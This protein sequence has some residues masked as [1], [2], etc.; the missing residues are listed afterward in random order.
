MERD[1]PK[2]ILSIRFHHVEVFGD[3]VRQYFF[4]FNAKPWELKTQEE[5]KRAREF[6]DEFV[7]SDMDSLRKSVYLFKKMVDIPEAKENLKYA[8]DLIGFTKQQSL[9]VVKGRLELFRSFFDLA[10]YENEFP[11]PLTSDLDTFCKTCAIGAHCHE[12]SVDPKENR[13]YVFQMALNAV[14]PNREPLHVT[15]KELFDRS[16]YQN[17]YEEVRKQGNGDWL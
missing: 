6:V 11:I 12:I 13:D 7:E 10:I 2:D 4:N 15:P 14:L 8:R 3:F 9:G 16:F 1:D 5:I 17:L